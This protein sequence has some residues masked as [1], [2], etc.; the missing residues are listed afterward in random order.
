MEIRKGG[1]PV[2]AAPLAGALTFGHNPAAFAPTTD[3]QLKDDAPMR[4]LPRI[5]AA[6]L[7]ATWAAPALAQD[8]TPPAATSASPAAAPADPVVAKVDATEIHMSDVRAA[9]VGIP[10]E[11]RQMPPQM[12]VPMLVD[13]LIDRAALLKLA[14]AQGLDKDPGVASAMGR[15][16]DQALQNAL[17][18]RAVGPQITEQA[19][20]ARYDATLANKPGEAE[21]HARHILVKDEDKA[22]DLIAQLTKG[23][24]FVQ[25]A[26]ANSTDPGAAEGGDLG[27]FKKGDMLPEF[28]EA[29]FALP[30]NGVT[31]APVHTRYGW[32]VIQTLGHRTAAPQ[33]FEQAREALR[34]SMIQ[35]AVQAEVKVARAGITFEKMPVG[36]PPAEPA[37]APAAAPA[38]P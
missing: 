32:H 26:K 14:R 13:Q 7:L 33:S 6:A 34:Q 28:A 19:I 23:G 30:D 31:Q 35:D 24:D 9:A 27:W 16:S 4:H 2:N 3:R 21:V 15:A 11:Y 38:T 10:E 29:A 25:L 5:A 22:K 12:L 8:A 36:A 18:G 37:P 20:K 17:I 1:C